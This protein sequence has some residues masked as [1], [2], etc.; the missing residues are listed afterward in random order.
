M[1]AWLGQ[2]AP[3]LQA[4]RLTLRSRPLGDP[5]T[6][7]PNQRTRGHCAHAIGLDLA[8]DQTEH[9]EQAPRI[10]SPVVCARRASASPI[11][12]TW[13]MQRAPRVEH[14]DCAGTVELVQKQSRRPRVGAPGP[15]GTFRHDACRHDACRRHACCVH[16]LQ[17]PTSLGVRAPNRQGS[18]GREWRGCDLACNVGL[19][20]LLACI[21]YGLCADK[22]GGLDDGTAVSGQCHRLWCD[23]RDWG[24]EALPVSPPAARVGGRSTCPHPLDVFIIPRSRSSRH[25]RELSEAAL[26]RWFEKTGTNRQADLVK[27]VAAY[28]NPLAA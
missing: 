11:S 24:L 20:P 27:L 15:L 28:C 23:Y 3:C 9:C 13:L 7:S 26:G 21:R 4:H 25:W 16:A 8:R 19:I 18:Y 2:C 1:V 10:L 17:Q 14:A 22:Q 5:T 6:L 12:L